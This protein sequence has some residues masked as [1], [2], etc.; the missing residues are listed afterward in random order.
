MTDTRTPFALAFA[1]WSAAHDAR[2]SI[3]RMPRTPHALTV[4]IRAED[5]AQVALIR[6]LTT[7][8]DEVKQRAAFVLSL[9]TDDCQELNPSPYIDRRD[10]LAL[11]LLVLEVANGPGQTIPQGA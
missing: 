9:L 5:A 1:F 2:R 11:V 4:A 3:E 7:T 10:Y 8:A 6:T